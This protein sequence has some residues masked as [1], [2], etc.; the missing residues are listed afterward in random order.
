MAKGDSPARQVPMSSIGFL[1][2]GH[3][4]G[5][6]GLFSGGSIFWKSSAPGCQACCSGWL[7]RGGSR[8]RARTR[9][10]FLREAG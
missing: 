5:G 9:L 4:G 8:K 10:S 3:W 2:R 7:S 6:A 1:Q